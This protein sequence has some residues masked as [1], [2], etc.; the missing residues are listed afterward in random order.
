MYGCFT[1]GK[2]VTKKRAL[3]IIYNDTVQ[4]FE[5]VLVVDKSFTIHHQN[6]QSLAI[7]TYKFYNAINNLPGGNLT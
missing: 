5:N 1:E 3:R 6:I 7:K 4:S 2:S